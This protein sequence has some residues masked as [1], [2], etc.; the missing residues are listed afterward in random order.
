MSNELISYIVAA[1]CGLLVV[2]AFAWFILLPAWHSYWKL[3]DRIAACFLALYVLLALLTVGA[4]GGVA[5]IYF[6]D[7]IAG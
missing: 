4:A 1:V 6:W 5:V 7:T 3:R 2:G